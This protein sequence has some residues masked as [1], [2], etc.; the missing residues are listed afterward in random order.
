M[1]R[2]LYVAMS[3]AKHI[4]QAQT[5]N[6]H[7]LSNVNT[8]GFRADLEQFRSMPV[9]G[10]G[11]PSR[12]Y[13]MVERPGVDFTPGVLQTTGRNL[14]VAI[15]GQ[16]W[17]AVQSKDG[18]EAYSR[19][20]ELK[21]TPEGL[22]QTADGLA[23]LGNGGPIALPPAQKIEFGADGTISI[24]PLGE[25][26]T[27][28]AIVDQIKLVNPPAE[29]LEK[30]ND[31]LFYLKS[32]SPASPGADVKLVSG[33]LESSNVK[34]VDAMVDMIELARRFEL[35]V[36]IMKTISDNDAASAQLMRFA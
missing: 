23:V 19:A 18:S 3:G 10:P 28:L 34:A 6:S 1:D 27:T 20:G 4:L 11:F 24:V 17:L 33:A 8:T 12:V 32:E 5:S 36:K 13:A 2:S 14:D 22:L 7:N 16:G 35:Q 9:F 21:L 15:H 25:G 29:Q 31:G 30:R 26:L